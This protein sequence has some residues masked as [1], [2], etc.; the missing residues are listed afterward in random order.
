MGACLCEPLAS[1]RDEVAAFD[2][3]MRGSSPI[4]GIE[5]WNADT[6]RM[7]QGAAVECLGHVRVIVGDAAEIVLNPNS[8]SSFQQ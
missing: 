6:I 3:V 8:P 5:S 4:N 2:D 7:S 1:G